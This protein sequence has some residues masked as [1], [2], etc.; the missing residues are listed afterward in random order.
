M[1]NL[2]TWFPYKLRRRRKILEVILQDKW[3][4][5]NKGRFPENVHLYPAKVPNSFMGCSIKAATI[6]VDPHVTLT[7]N[8]TNSDS[9]IKYK[10]T[11]LSVE[12]FSSVC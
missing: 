12:I 4:S 10:V 3:L 2:Y 5:E 7:E 11:G 9:G 6:G 1:L 8:Y